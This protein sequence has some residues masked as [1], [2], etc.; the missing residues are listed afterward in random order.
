VSPTY[1]PEH[2]APPFVRPERDPDGP[3][4]DGPSSHET[5]GQFPADELDGAVAPEWADG[6]SAHETAGEFPADEI[7]GDNVNTPNEPEPVPEPAP[8]PPTE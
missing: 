3:A 2:E 7:Q 1:G 8:E 6:P 4:D 5:A